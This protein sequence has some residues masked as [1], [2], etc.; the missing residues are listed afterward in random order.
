MINRL[1]IYTVL[2]TLLHPLSFTIG[3]VILISV[4]YKLQ[5]TSFNNIYSSIVV[6]STP[7][8]HV[9]GPSVKSQLRVLWLRSSVVSLSHPPNRCRDNTLNYAMAA[10]FHSFYTSLFANHPNISQYII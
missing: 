6:I 3:A 5:S 10:S 1:G 4:R 2:Q 7:A 8:A 9:R